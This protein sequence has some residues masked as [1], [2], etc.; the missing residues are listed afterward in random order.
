MSQRYKHDS[1]PL[2]N[3]GRIDRSPTKPS[4]S[5]N[6]KIGEGVF[7][8]TA[9]AATLAGAIKFSG[10]VI[11][12]ID[13]SSHPAHVAE[14][15]SEADYQTQVLRPAIEAVESEI[16][17]IRVTRDFLK[18]QNALDAAQLEIDN[19]KGNYKYSF[20]EGDSLLRH[21]EQSESKGGDSKVEL[22][23]S[24]S[25]KV[26]HD[27]TGTSIVV[28]RGSNTQVDGLGG[29]HNMK[30]T[31]HNPNRNLAVDLSDLSTLAGA[32]ASPDTKVT[33]A[34]AS[35]SFKSDTHDDQ[36]WYTSDSP[37]TMTFTQ[38]E[39]GSFAAVTNTE[40]LETGYGVSQN[41][42]PTIDD[43]LEFEFDQ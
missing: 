9:G 32:I 18:D 13:K 39:D 4:K 35:G 7:W 17:S 42:T 24:G 16:N 8:A 6:R 1:S 15:I 28:E 34:V 40:A 20:Y 11:E 29:Y 14:Q 12:T 36:S 23:S 37:L 43:V 31:F 33:S 27:D 5:R 25:V 26:D 22:T 19:E 38:N 2:S 3:Y 41:A 30:I 10:P 21:A